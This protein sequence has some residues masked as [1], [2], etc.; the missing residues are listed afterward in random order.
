MSRISLEEQQ[1]VASAHK[2]LVERRFKR[3]KNDMEEVIGR[4][5]YDE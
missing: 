2:K 3:F 1:G 4:R 5:H